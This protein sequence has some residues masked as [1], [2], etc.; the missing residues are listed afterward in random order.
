MKKTE[1]DIYKVVGYEFNI[2]SST[3][4][5]D[6]LDRAGVDT[7]ERTAKG[8]MKTGEDMLIKIADEYPIVRKIIDYRHDQKKLGTYVNSMIKEVERTGNKLHFKYFMSRVPSARLAA[9]GDKKNPYYAPI[10]IQNIIKPGKQMFKAVMD[11]GPKSVLGWSFTPTDEKKGDNLI[12][13]MDPNENLRACFTL[14]EDHYWVSCDFCLSEDTKIKTPDGDMTALQVFQTFKKRI[15]QVETPLGPRQVLK[16]EKT[17][18]MYQYDIILENGVNI[19]CSYNHVWMVKEPSGALLWKETHA[20]NLSD[21]FIAAGDGDFI[22]E[23]LQETIVKGTRDAQIVTGDIQGTVKI[24]DIKKVD[25]DEQDTVMYDFEIEEAHCF[26]AGGVVSH[27]SGQELR[28]PAIFSGEPLMVNTFKNNGDLHGEV[29]VRM[30]IDRPQAKT[31][32]FGV[33]YG[34]SEYTMYKAL[35]IPLD[36]AKIY[37]DGWWKS[38]PKLDRWAKSV[39]RE[40]QKTG[41][42]T[43]YF[44]RRRPL[45]FWYKSGNRKLI[46]FANRSALNHKIQSTGGDIMR[47]CLIKMYK[48]LVL[49]KEPG[50]MMLSSIHDEINMAMHKDVIRELLPRVVN[51]MEIQMPSWPIKLTVGIEIGW[52]WGSLFSFKLTDGELLPAF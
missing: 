11:D 10:N 48:E 32:N 42:S 40:S 43:N 3:Q 17:R 8:Q 51:L 35:G 15:V 38:M 46:G 25:P 26:F 47:I 29:A 31:L 45:R 50:F 41:Y 52:T 13:G 23:L 18:P 6:A 30:G 39:K 12:E 44:G 14:P 19:R 27:N 34:G 33:L 22:R 20:V 21:C 16:A 24:Y 2:N 5:A 36:K 9:G 37:I 7:G 28:L 1:S 4:I 49:Q